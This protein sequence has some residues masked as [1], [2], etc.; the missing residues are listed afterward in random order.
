LYLTDTPISKTHTEQEIRAQVQV[1]G[2]IY[3]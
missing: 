2:Q 3:L 1:G